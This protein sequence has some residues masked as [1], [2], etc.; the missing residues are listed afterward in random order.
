MPPAW[1]LFVLACSLVQARNFNITYF[2]VPDVVPPGQLEVE[3]ECRYDANFTILS[4]FKGP[5]EF[6]RYKPGTTPSTHSFS[7]KGVGTIDVETCGPTACVLKLGALTEDA[8]GLYR[9]DIE[10]NI[11]PHMFETRSANMIVHGA[12]RRKPLVEGLAKEFGEDDLMQAYCRATPG[13]DIRWYLNGRELE[14]FR[15]TPAFRMKSSR[16]LFSGL[17]PTVTIQCAELRDEKLSGSKGAVAYW[18]ES[19]R[20]TLG[21]NLRLP[22]ASVAFVN[23]L[24]FMYILYISLF[25]I[26]F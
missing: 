11:A 9:C 2:S 6:F 12:V 15:N 23:N 18:K 16:L 21:E 25:A 17:P 26:L 5:N 22:N 7:V 20:T 13:V 19:Y 8:S 10:R 14:K 4:W 1:L 24:K 3:I